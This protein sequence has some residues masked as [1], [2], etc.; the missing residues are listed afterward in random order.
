MSGTNRKSGKSVVRAAVGAALLALGLSTSGC[1]TTLVTG[2]GAVEP[3]AG[4]RGDLELLQRSHDGPALTALLVADV[5][6]SFAADTALLPVT[7]PAGIA[8]ACR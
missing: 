1:A 8:H 4:T 7:V 6:L 2:L 5:P 3:Y